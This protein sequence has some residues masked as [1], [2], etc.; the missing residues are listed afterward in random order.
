[1]DRAGEMTLPFKMTG[2][3]VRPE[4]MVLL[5]TGFPSMELE[6][7]LDPSTPEKPAGLAPGLW[8]RGQALASSAYRSVQRAG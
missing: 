5:Q 7:P 4:E 3:E 8:P 2:T 1:M 6:P